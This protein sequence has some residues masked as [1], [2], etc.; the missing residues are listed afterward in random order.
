VVL[1]GDRLP[2]GPDVDVEYLAARFELCGGDIRNAV[3]TAAYLAADR[4]DPVGMRDLVRAVAREY[5][6]LGRLCLPQ[7]FGE[8]FGV[9]D[10]LDDAVQAVTAQPL[11]PAT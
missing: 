10:E 4:D 11:A 2:L 6:K 8:W 3:T 5:R 1:S 7:E 9:I